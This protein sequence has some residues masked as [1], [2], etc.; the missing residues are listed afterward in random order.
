MTI[1]GKLS[2]GRYIGLSRIAPVRA[3]AKR[4]RER[5]SPR[6]LALVGNL[7]YWWKPSCAL[8]GCPVSHCRGLGTMMWRAT[9]YP[10]TSPTGHRV[11]I[12]RK[13]RADCGIGRERS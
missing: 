8:R 3:T 13:V 4:L 6:R 2:V 5:S 7:F 11:E 1:N 10:S 9:S 12:R